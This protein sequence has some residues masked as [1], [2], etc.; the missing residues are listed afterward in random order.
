MHENH[1]GDAAVLAMEC[2]LALPPSDDP[3]APSNTYV[4]Y[5]DGSA[6]DN[7]GPAGW[8]VVA[9]RSDGRRKELSGG[10]PFATN[11]QMELK[12]AIEALRMLKPGAVG[13]V[14][15]DSKYVVQGVHVWRPNWEANGWRTS[16]GASVKN[17]ELWRELFAL[18]DARPGIRFVWVKGHADNRH[19]NR[20]DKL[21]NA[22]A[23]KMK[24][25][26][27]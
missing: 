17:P 4:I 16:G 6:L 7:P 25:Q 13:T 5:T 19:N 22:A 1:S 15:T 20:A 9:I 21:A 23:A 26:S 8:A 24:E 3:A 18:F 2:A 10:L 14:Y 27:K 12:A 11:Q